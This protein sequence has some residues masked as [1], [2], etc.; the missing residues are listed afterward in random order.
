V[1]AISRAPKPSFAD[2]SGRLSHGASEM[3]SQTAKNAGR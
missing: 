3:T 1:A 2:A